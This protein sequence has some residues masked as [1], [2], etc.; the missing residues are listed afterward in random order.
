MAGPRLILI[1]A[2]ALTVVY[3]SLWQYMRAGHK[4]RLAEEWARDRPPLPRHTHVE[5]GLREAAPRL[6]RQLI[7]WVYVVPVSV[8]TA[9]ILI[10]NTV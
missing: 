1:L 10:F 4:D 7:L 5:I 6:R 8:V 3:W 9:T 2:V